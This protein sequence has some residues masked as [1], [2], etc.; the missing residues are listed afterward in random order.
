LKSIAETLAHL[1]A[2]GVVHRDLKPAHIMFRDSEAVLID[3]GVA[4]LVGSA[5]RL[6]AGEIV[7]S[8]AWMAPEQ[9]LGAAPEPSADIWSFCAVAHRVLN[10][11]PLYMGTAETVLDARQAG[12]EPKPDFSTLTDRRLAE[13]LHAGFAAPAARPSA[14]ELAMALS[15]VGSSSPVAL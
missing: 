2:C 6:D 10:G 12:T 3:L 14:H 4:G 11:R 15:G 9:M 13:A 5:D 1:H 7:G 8:P